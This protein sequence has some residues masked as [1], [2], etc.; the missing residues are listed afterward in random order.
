[1]GMPSDG[2]SSYLSYKI[3]DEL[4]RL[5]ELKAGGSHGADTVLTRLFLGSAVLTKVSLDSM[6]LFSLSTMHALCS[7]AGSLESLTFLGIVCP[8]NTLNTIGAH[9]FNLT[10]FVLASSAESTELPWITERGLLAI[11]EGCHRLQHLL[12]VIKEPAVTEAVLLAIAAHCH[13]LEQLL[14]LDDAILTDAAL[15][16]LSAGC[17]KLQVLQVGYWGIRSVASVD[18]AQS[19]LSRLVRCACICALEG[20]PATVARA[21]THMK[22]LSELI[23]ESAWSDH[24]AALHDAL[25]AAYGSVHIACREDQVV[26]LDNVMVRLVHSSLQL[27]SVSLRGGCAV[28][29]ATLLTIAELCTEVGNVTVERLIGTITES[30]L[31]KLLR[32][33][34]HLTTVN[35]NHNVAFTDA[36]LQTIA[37]YCPGLKSLN[38]SSNTIVSEAAVLELVKDR[39]T[40]LEP[41][42]TFCAETRQKIQEAVKL[43]RGF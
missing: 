15:V 9:C 27:R 43:R 33:W 1:M 4:E 18:A 38:L 20:A 25:F 32:C 31:V 28:T 11:A 22:S 42:A 5:V 16:A 13:E 7:C 3:W 40:T 37:Q 12:L 6:F 26:S 35:I 36:V 41:P 8:L 39:F 10:V 29:E 17:M 21:V 30:A 19:L 24:I 2:D 14:A 34:P 23:V